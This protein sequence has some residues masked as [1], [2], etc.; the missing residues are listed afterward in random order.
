M[1]KFYLIFFLLNLLLS[2]WFLD[3][4]NNAN[5]TSRA[6]PVVSWFEDGTLRIDK[7][8]ELT[9]DKAKINGHY[10]T[11]KAPLPTL[12]TIPFYGLIKKLGWVEQNE[13][14]SRGKEVYL[15]GS[16]LCGSLIFSLILTITLAAVRK[17]KN[18]LSAIFLVMMPFYGSFIFVYSGTFYAHLMSSSLILLGYLMIRKKQYV[19]AGVFSGLAFLSEYTLALFFPVWAL[20]IWIQEKS[21]FKGILFGLG[22]LPAIVFIGIYNYIFTGSPFEM[23]YKYHT[24]QFLHENYG[25]RLPSLESVWGLTFSNFKGLFFYAPFLILFLVVMIRRFSWQVFSH[26]FLTWVSLLFFLVIASYDVWW[27]GWCYGSR[28][29]FPVAVLLIFE[30]VQQLLKIRFSKVL[31]WIL[32]GFGLAG[33]FLAKIT[34]VYSIPSGASNPFFDTIFPN[35]RLENFNPNNLLTMIFGMEPLFSGI[36]WLVIFLFSIIMLKRLH[37]KIIAKH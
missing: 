37:K 2:S 4:W 30:G 8:H 9:P 25:F 3:T 15:L 34:V 20:Q 10:Y 21:F 7:Y 19:W 14:N 33:A 5:T 31:F 11:D 36:L 18:Q 28:L 26:H 35:I 23:L 27:G 1:K 24:F 6:L 12:I 17:R 29:L 16:I 13:D 32:T 22:T